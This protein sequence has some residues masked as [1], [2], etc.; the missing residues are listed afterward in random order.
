[1]LLLLPFYDRT[2]G[3]SPLKRPVASGVAMVT[4]VAIAFLTYQGATAPTPPKAG[5]LVSEE[6][7]ALPP[8]SA[9]G[10]EIYDAQGCPA[11]HVL[12]GAGSPAGPDLTRIG[13][14]RDAEWLKRFMKEPA[15]VMP[16]S[17]MPPYAELPEE[18]LDALAKYLASLK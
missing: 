11:C 1:L 9:K 14:K 13:A 16:G 15:A 18:E 10:R 17:I 2:P 6:A 7:Q 3:R 5:G 4:L 8:E 12:K